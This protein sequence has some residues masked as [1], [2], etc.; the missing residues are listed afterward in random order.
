VRQYGWIRELRGACA[1]SNVAVKAHFLQ[2][3]IM[4]A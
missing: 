2:W 1:D 4:G 3:D